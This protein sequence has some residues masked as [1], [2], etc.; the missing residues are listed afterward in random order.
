MRNKAAH[1]YL[2]L[3]AETDDPQMQSIL[4]MYC[5][6]KPDED[7]YFDSDEFQVEYDKYCRTPIHDLFPYV[8]SAKKGTM[9][10]DVEALERMSTSLMDLAN[11]PLQ[12]HGRESQD[13]HYLMTFE[14]ETSDPQIESLMDYFCGLK[15]DDDAYLASDQFRDE[16]TKYCTMPVTKLIHYADGG[17]KEQFRLDPDALKR[18][19]A[20]LKNLEKLF[21]KDA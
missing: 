10:Y 3:E 7:A 1:Y 2:T 4:D 9:R 8:L 21:E 20:Q 16:Y 15:P 5:G 17:Q 18:L 11:H 6:L 19:S 12:E 13:S 14:I